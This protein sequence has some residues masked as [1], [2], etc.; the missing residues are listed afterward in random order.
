MRTRTLA[1]A[2]VAAASLVLAAC[3]GGGGGGAA[4]DGEGDDGGGAATGAPTVVTITAPAGA[5]NTGFAETAVSAPAD[6]PFTIH[7]VNDDPGIPHNVQIFEGEDASGT[8]VWAPE[9]GELVTG[10][11]EVDYEI[12]ALPAGT[13]TFNCL[14]HPT[15]MVGTLTVG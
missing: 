1:L 7:F 15:T 10:P 5:A 12:P 14:A 6:T 3:G 8:P 9:G 13:Y 4:G 2:L 11:A